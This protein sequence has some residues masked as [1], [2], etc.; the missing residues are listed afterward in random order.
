MLLGELGPERR[1][2]GGVVVAQRDSAFA[3]NSGGG[4]AGELRH[5]RDHV[6]AAFAGDAQTGDADV[7][8]V[9]A[10]RRADVFFLEAADPREQV[11]RPGAEPLVVALPELGQRVFG[12]RADCV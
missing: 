2:G 3:A 4:V 6:V 11:Q 5:Q 12:L 8:V 1:G 7:R 9:V 10:K